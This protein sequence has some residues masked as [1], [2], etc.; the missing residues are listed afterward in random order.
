M[1]IRNSSP[2]SVVSQNSLKVLA[3]LVWYLGGVALLY[4]GGRL[5]V[6][7]D[8]LEPGDLWPWVAAVGG[9]LIGGLKARFLFAETCRKNL[10]RISALDAPRLWQ[11]YRPG[12]FLL[13]T[14]MI[15]TGVT[16]SRLAHG[17]YWF[18]IGVAT[19]DLSIAMALLGSSYIFWQR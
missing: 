4:K 13:L 1:I 2:L 14:A 19:L 8:A 11:F 18:L 16:L 17:N 10:A 7:A 9:L 15:F 3:A 6:E 12:F 5:L